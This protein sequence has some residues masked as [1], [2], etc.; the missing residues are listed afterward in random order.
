MS[1]QQAPWTIGR[2]IEWTKDHLREKGADAPRLATELLLAH[3]LGC[4]RIELYA[5]FEQIPGA[6]QLALFRDLVRRAALQE[7]I[8]YLIGK[9]EFF[10]LDFEVSP[11]VLI[12]R[13]ETEVL[14]DQTIQYCKSLARDSIDILDL[15]TGS[16]CV[17]LTIC[18]Y[19]KSARVLG[20]DICE[21]A[22][23]VA[24]R[25]A[26]QLGLDDRF[27][28][29][30]ADGFELPKKV[31]PRDG[32]DVVVSNPPY[33]SSQDMRSLEERVIKYEPRQALFGGEDGLLFYRRI[34]QEAGAVLKPAAAIFLEVGYDQHDRA[35]EILT[36]HKKF[37]HVQSWRDR[38]EGHL[39]VLQ[40]E[41]LTKG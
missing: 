33:V 31:V 11:K 12:P 37:H 2:L 3:A 40:F 1:T 27:E 22:V 15:G 35:I 18:H 8:A 19:V 41:R 10:S 7:P 28:P 25:N 17:G 34:A 16:G 13:P 38:N 39:R 29:V 6:D 24:R 4:A 21:A 30:V 9:K 14:T 32:F 23:E 5:R 36:A 26:R 20:S